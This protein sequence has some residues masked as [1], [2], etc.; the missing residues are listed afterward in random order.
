MGETRL[1][2]GRHCST[3]VGV[4]GKPLLTCP[5]DWNGPLLER[6]EIPGALEC[7]AQY[8]GMPI[9][10][11]PLRGHG[12]RRFRSGS[13]IQEFY[14]AQPNILIYGETFERDHGRWDG[15][16]GESITLR[17][18]SRVLNRYGQDDRY[19]FDTRFNNVD[20]TLRNA[21]TALAEEVQCGF[22]NG[23]LYAE[24]LSISIVGWLMTHYGAKSPAVASPKRGLSAVHQ[25]RIEEFIDS[26]LDQNISIECMAAQ[27][28]MSPRLFSRVFPVA[29]GESPHRYVTLKRLARAKQLLSIRPNLTILDVALRTGFSSQ[30]HFCFAF[31]KFFGGTPTAWRNDR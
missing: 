25:A 10:I 27:V 15:E 23:R 26:H 6:K 9:V 16:P 3:I 17:L 18:P 29:Y 7:G 30:A 31:R 14:T 4:D 24:G 13:T 5:R 20:P 19:R 8:S 28:S 12:K 21:I 11:V 22:P 1:P 2:V